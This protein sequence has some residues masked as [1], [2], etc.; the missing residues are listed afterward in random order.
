[1]GNVNRSGVRDVEILLRAHGL[2]PAAV[3]LPDALERSYL[4]PRLGGSFKVWGM[5]RI[6][7]AVR[8]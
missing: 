8:V 6:V 3:L 5:M 2:R 7:H 4:S 1:M